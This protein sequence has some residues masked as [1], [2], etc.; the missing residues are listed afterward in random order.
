MKKLI[1]VTS[2]PASGKTYIAKK[3]AEALRHVVYLDKD[4]LIKLSK[5]IFV[6]AGEEYN[7]SS[8][9]FNENIRDYEYETIVEIAMEALNYDDIVLINAPFTK[10]IRDLNYIKK[11]KVALKD[12]NAS[13]VI[14][15][16]ETSIEVTRQR[17]IERN[18]DR[19]TWKLA[20]WNEYVTGIN[21]DVPIALDDPCIK[22]DLLIFQNSSEEEFE[23]S[24]TKTIDILEESS[25]RK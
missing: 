10:E 9:F 17:M 25:G 24:L 12:K 23:G 7:R 1:L 11:L 20:N 8:D 14:I 22:D 3:L 5:Q 2:P 4:T 13:L 21:F 19:D 18:S 15:W 6:V 16:V